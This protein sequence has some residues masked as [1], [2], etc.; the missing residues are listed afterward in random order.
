[1]KITNKIKT[2]KNKI[3]T[4]NFV[5]IQLM[6]TVVILLSPLL[7]GC[8][9]TGMLIEKSQNNTKVDN[10][11]YADTITHIGIPK[12]SLKDFPYALV[13]IGDKQSYLITSEK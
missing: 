1:M 7:S 4:I 2:V 11:L 5:K 3:S 10:I 8:V 9:A 13:M 12:S 6:G